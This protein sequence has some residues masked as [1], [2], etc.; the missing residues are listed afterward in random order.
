M[1]NNSPLKLSPISG[2]SFKLSSEIGESLRLSPNPWLSPNLGDPLLNTVLLKWPT[3]LS[4]VEAFVTPKDCCVQQELFRWRRQVGLAACWLQGWFHGT[5]GSPTASECACVP[6]K[7]TQNS[8]DCLPKKRR[9]G[10]HYCAVHYLV[11]NAFVARLRACKVLTF[12]FFRHDGY[13]NQHF[14][15]GT[16]PLLFLDTEHLGCSHTEYTIHRRFRTHAIHPYPIHDTHVFLI[17]KWVPH[18]NYVLGTW[19]TARIGL[20]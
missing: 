6:D 16:H 10:C 2:E 7:Q 17:G 13:V 12:I 3:L 5:K 14:V 4:N 19:Y 18:A 9:S 1:L 11:P 8:M 15:C 20:I